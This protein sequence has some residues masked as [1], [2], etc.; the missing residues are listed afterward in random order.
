MDKD[1]EMLVVSFCIQFV[2]Y[3]LSC[4]CVLEMR[5]NPTSTTLSCNKGGPVIE[6]THVKGANVKQD[7]RSEEICQLRTDSSVI[8]L[9]KP[10]IVAIPG[11]RS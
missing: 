3:L 7:E 2:F 8:L 11:P 6:I 5:K 10:T 4:V 1:P 9:C